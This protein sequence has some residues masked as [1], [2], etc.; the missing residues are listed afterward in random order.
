[1]EE[2]GTLTVNADSKY[3]AEQQDR[4]QGMINA[5]SKDKVKEYLHDHLTLLTYD[6][7]AF[8]YKENKSELPSVNERLDIS[9]SNYATITGR[10]FNLLYRM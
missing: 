3:D 8:D 1:L 7:S 9:V 10:P 2:D 4:I 6:I 5:L